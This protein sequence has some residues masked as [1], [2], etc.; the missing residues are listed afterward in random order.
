VTIT[1]VGTNRSQQVK[2][3]SDGAFTAP[4]LE[5]VVYRIAVEAPGFKKALV[6]NVKVDTATTASVNVTLEAGATT[7]EVTITAEAPLLSAESGT[8][9][10]TISERQI[11]DLP[12]NNRSVLDLALT[13]GNVSGVAG[14]EDPEL[15]QDIPAPGFNVNVNGGRAGSTAILADG[16]NNTGA[17]LG[18]AVVTFSPDTIQ[19]FTVQ[20]SNF[21][22]EFGMTGGGV[23]NMTT[24]SGTNRYNGLAYWYHRNPSLNAAPFTTNANNRPLSNRRQ[25]Q[26]GLTM[27]GPVVLPKK[28]FGPAGY[29]GHD[30]TFFFA[31]FEPRYYYDASQFTSLLATPEMLRGDFSGLVRV[32]GGLAPRAAAEKF[33]IQNQI[34]D[35]TIYNQWLN[36]NG[37]FTRR[38]LAAGETYPAFPDNKIP[39]NML[40]PVSQK[41]LQ[42]IPTGGEYF[43]SDGNL[44]NYAS[45]SFVKNFEKRLTI[46]LDHQ[47][48]KNNRV[49]GRYTQVPIRGDRGRGDFQVGRDEINSG[50]TDY[51]WSKQVLITDTHTFSARAVNELRLNYTFGRFT[52]NFPPEFDALSGRNLSTE[53]G[54][55][56][57]TAGGLPEFTTGPA[58]V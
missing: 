43:L 13:V 12:L 19:E 1:N 26:F 10:Q 20:T 36:N 6:E 5:P 23:I 39:A 14:T 48:N 51:S 32:N 57:L 21:S 44:R 2:T 31:A 58:S 29:D 17:G 22:A 3:S 15:G 55:P 28:I 7:A 33:G 11:T 46:K 9:G 37:I 38:T 47:I 4:S 41:L 49:S 34:L 42:Y 56:S 8:H 16:A 40:D 30:K 25:H 52:K 24:K 18:R 50:G 54:L 35:A 53:L 27:G 45:E